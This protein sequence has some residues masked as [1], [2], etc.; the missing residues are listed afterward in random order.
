MSMMTSGNHD[1]HTA[2]MEPCRRVDPT[3]PTSRSPRTCDGGCKPANGHPAQ[4][5]RQRPS[6]PG[7][8]TWPRARSPGRCE[9]SPQTDWCTPCHAG[10]PWPG[11][12]QKMP[13]RPASTPATAQRPGPPGACCH[14]HAVPVPVVPPACARCFAGAVP[15]LALGVPLGVRVR[16]GTAQ[17][18]PRR[19]SSQVGGTTGA[20]TGRTLAA[21]CVRWVCGCC[22]C[23]GRGRWAPPARGRSRLRHLAWCLNMSDAVRAGITPCGR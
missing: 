2:I 16:S 14:G 23:F 3:C 6:W 5:S 15:D 12:R 1:N 22:V 10:P 17:A 11:H 7:T 20:P 13:L 9:S 18:D 19:G 4:P 8:T 21:R